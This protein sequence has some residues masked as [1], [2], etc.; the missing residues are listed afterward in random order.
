MRGG[1][2]PPMIF[3]AVLTTCWR[4]SGSDAV[5]LLKVEMLM[6]FLGYGTSDEGPGEVL[7]PVHTDKFDTLDNFHTGAVDA[8]WRVV[9]VFFWSQSISLFLS[10]LRDALLTLHQS[11]NR[12]TSSLCADSLFLL[13]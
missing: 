5:Q 3:S 9:T 6:G 7:H 4:A 13:V 8:Q 12:C 2:E 10:T 1:R 11:V